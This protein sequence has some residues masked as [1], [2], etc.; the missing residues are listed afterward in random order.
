VNAR[1]LRRALLAIQPPDELGATRRSWQVARAA[2]D[3]REPT[4]WPR[5]HA[6][7]LVAGAVA[8][9]ALAALVSPQGR[10]VIAD[11]REALGTEKAAE[12]PQARP[13][14][15]SLPAEG[16]VLVTAPR[17]VWVVEANGSKRRLGDFDEAS[18]SPGGLAVAST[19]SRLAAFGPAGE[20][21]WTLDRPRVHDARWSPEG[22]RIAYLSGSNVR[23]VAADKSGDRRVDGAADVA[24][25][26]RPGEQPVLAYVSADGVLTVRD[27]D[28]DGTL[29]TSGVRGTPAHLEWS[30]DGR[31]LVAAVPLSES[32][33]A[34]TVYDEAGRRLQSLPLPGTFVDAAFAPSD[35]RVAL[36]RRQGGEDGE[37]SEL[38]VVDADSI[39]RQTPVFSGRGRFSD[40]AWSPGTRWL[41]L[42]WQGADQWL[43][44]RSTAVEKVKAVSSLAQQFDPGG[45]GAGPFPRIEGWCCGG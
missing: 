28:T 8:I 21:R 42:G 40:V 37:T 6:G 17:G 14:S 12:V 34:L 27:T 9:A 16:R 30:A 2:F 45:T 3:E 35:H 24:P 38:L 31:R 44:I 36:I 19:R 33:F 41:L 43:F 32:R 25:A 23:V 4:P 7:W 29:W 11:V 5:R 22:S 13:A 20:I 15:F 18:L 26:W 39:R 1:E 10:E